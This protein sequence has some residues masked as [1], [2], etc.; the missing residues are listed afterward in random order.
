M[1][2]AKL[3]GWTYLTLIASVT[4]SACGG[5][6]RAGHDRPPA[7]SD[8]ISVADAQPG[9]SAG[10]SAEQNPS[11]GYAASSQSCA[12][13]SLCRLAGHCAARDGDCIAS[14]DA[15]CEQSSQCRT[16]GACAVARDECVA[17]SDRHCRQSEACRKERRCRA[18][19]GYCVAS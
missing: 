4:V 17:A 7:A 13:T 3:L 6:P 2:T 19:D 16:D 12:D 15:D 8:A 9:T 11:L 18:K 5:A 14:R 10:R 1:T